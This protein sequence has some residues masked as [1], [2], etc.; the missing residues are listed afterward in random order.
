[1]ADRKNV[2]VH[3]VFD[4]RMAGKKLAVRRGLGAIV[5]PYVEVLQIAPTGDC[6]L[7]VR[8]DETMGESHLIFHC[9]GIRTILPFTLT[10]AQ[11]VAAAE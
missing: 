2:L 10:S 1:M 8:L 7:N 5:D 9:E 3:L 4:R 6:T 11:V